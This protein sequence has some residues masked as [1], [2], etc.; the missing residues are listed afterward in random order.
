MTEP[1]DDCPECG[2]GRLFERE[3]GYGPFL[4]CSTYPECTYTEEDEE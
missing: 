2:I 3:G 1:G 4:G